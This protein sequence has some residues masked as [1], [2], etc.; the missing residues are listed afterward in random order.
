MES[1]T[2]DD[3]DWQLIADADVLHIGGPDSLGPFTAEVLPRLLR[4]AREHGVV[5][6]MDLLRTAVS[7]ELFDILRPSWEHTQYL[8]PNDDQIRA[9]TGTGDLREAA[10]AV[11]AGGVGTVIVTMGGEG[12]LLVA[13]DALE[14]I[15]A[16]EVPVVDTTGC[17]DAYSASFI[18]GLCQGWDPL[19]SARLG[20]AA[21]ALVAQG[22]GSDAGIVDLPDTLGFWSRRASRVGA[23][24]PT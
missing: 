16:F 21:S 6:T 12:S 4:F 24:P 2:A 20:T 22:L 7:P 23:R 14:R 5:T 1:L 3:I 11:R 9:L 10:E 13:E 8:L 18:T 17:G 15:P 19:A